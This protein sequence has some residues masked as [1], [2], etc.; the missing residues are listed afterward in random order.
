MLHMGWIRTAV[1]F[2]SVSKRY[3][4]LI[5]LAMITSPWI[6]G[7]EREKTA[8]PER[9]TNWE[10]LLSD[11]ELASDPDPHAPLENPVW[12]AWIKDHHIPIRSLDAGN[13]ADLEPLRSLLADRRLV[14]LGESSHGVAEFNRVKTRLIKF[15]HQELDFDVIAFESSIFEC[16]QTDHA[17]D[18]LLAL[19]MMRHSIFS[20]WHTTDVKDLFDYMRDCH[21][22]GAPL[23]LA[24]FDTQISSLVG[25]ADRPEFL[26]ALLAALAPAYADTVEAFDR[27]FLDHY[28]NQRTRTYLQEHGAL[29]VHRYENLNTYLE[30]HLAELM[31]VLPGKQESIL[32][33]RQVARS[34]LWFV[35]QLRLQYEDDMAR[36]S[37][38]RDQGMAENL[39]FLLDELYPNRKVLVWA[40]NTHIRH[41][42]QDVQCP[43]Q[44]CLRTMGHWIVH[45]FRPEMYTI[46]L[47]MYRGQAAT[48]DRDIYDI[49]PAVSGSLESILYRAGR[50]H[51]IVD[52]LHRTPLEGN[53]WMFRS[54]LVKT[55]GL[56]EL[57]MV[58][59]DQYDGILFIDTAS[60]PHYYPRAK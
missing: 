18:S 45:R 6:G 3:A 20:V 30:D 52:L 16:F 25:S 34:M 37:Y 13:F 48:N 58:P 43:T 53:H 41:K 9:P 54:I 59:Q 33:A 21:F 4:A 14:Q 11:E 56:Q 10:G 19:D 29:V 26:H 47:Y 2:M 24:G 5:A 1:V 31:L 39:T 8:A 46:G 36:A 38:V 32:I 50:K 55:F 23:T 42:N 12:S 44:M 17:T 40:H 15:L 49:A 7:C 27:E 35:E 57:K 51:C 22:S 60:A 28:E